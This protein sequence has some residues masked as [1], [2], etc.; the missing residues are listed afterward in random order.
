MSA[1]STATIELV[2]VRHGQSEW[3]LARRMCGWSDIAL[4]EL[5]RAQAQAVG[6]F[7]RAHRFDRVW[8]SDLQRARDTARIALATEPT[9]DARLRE[10][11]FG[12]Y[13][14]ARWDEI[15]EWH[16]RDLKDF[17]RYAAP[18]G[19]SVDQLR[20]RVCGFVGELE[21]GRHAV[22][23]HGGVVRVLLHELQA[24]AFVPNCAVVE[25][26][27]SGRLLHAIHEP[28]AEVTAR[29]AATDG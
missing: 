6:A 17:A 23:C 11:D 14:G 15:P 10:L 12:H 24:A 20:E 22:F 18:G 28:A 13:D 9:T 4:T 19:E 3:N 7:L 27:W 1:G 26:D 29:W 8:S 2:V 5:G 25:L 21:P 16:Q